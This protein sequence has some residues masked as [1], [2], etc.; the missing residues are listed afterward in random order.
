MAARQRRRRRGARSARSLVLRAVRAVPCLTDAQIAARVGC[1]PSTVSRHRR[2]ITSG[3]GLAH[4]SPP[5]LERAVNDPGCSPPRLARLAC[6]NAQ[7]V[8]LA[9]AAHP[10]S[11]SFFLSRL[12]CDNVAWVRGGV[13]RR[14]DCPPRL[15]ALLSKDSAWIVR[16][17]VARNPAC[18]PQLVNRLASDSYPQV[19]FA[20]R[21]E[22]MRRQ[23]SDTDRRREVLLDRVWGQELMSSQ[24]P[25][26]RPGP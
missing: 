18:P 19:N 11:P 26:R 17:S 6:D 16:K 24:R 8:R 10:N 5:L 14:G 23:K 21:Q 4:G 3:M 2:S 9:A 13:A 22:L 25:E 15:L 12:A 7:A 20:A 1:H